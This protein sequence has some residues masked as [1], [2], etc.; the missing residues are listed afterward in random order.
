MARAQT[1]SLE[2]YPQS[3]PRDA[4]KLEWLLKKKEK[5]KGEAMQT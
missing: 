2:L 5:A 4:D 3:A 1:Q